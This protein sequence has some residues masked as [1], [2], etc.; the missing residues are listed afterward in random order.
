MRVIFILFVCLFCNFFVANCQKKVSLGL[1]IG[2][3]LNQNFLIQNDINAIS[4]I[5]FGDVKVNQLRSNQIALL[6]KNTIFEKNNISL[7]INYGLQISTQP[8][9]MNVFTPTS[10]TYLLNQKEF[11]ARHLEVPLFIDL[12]YRLG[13]ARTVSPFFRTGIYASFAKSEKFSFNDDK[14]L[15]QNK[16][17]F[18]NYSLE[19]NNNKFGIVGVLGIGLELNLQKNK[20]LQLLCSS[21]NRLTSNESIS[22]EV[23]ISGGQNITYDFLTPV[24]NPMNSLYF[25]MV[26][27]YTFG[28]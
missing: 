27:F 1:S 28:K 23:K 11:K 7:D 25:Q 2:T 17:Y 22:G 3:G 21:Q 24:K 16:A 6:L 26:Y 8:L 10:G 20:Q 15:S 4:V 19:Y 9:Q 13:E 18:G 12:K 5:N 14:P